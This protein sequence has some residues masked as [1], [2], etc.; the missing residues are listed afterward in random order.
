[1]R[2]RKI[3]PSCGPAGAGCSYVSLDGDIACLVNGAGLAMSTMDLIKYHGGE[4]ANFLDVGGGANKDQVLEGFRILLSAPARQGGAGQ[5]LRRHH[6]VRHDRNG[7]AGGLSTSSI[8]AFRWSSGS[9]GP[10]SSWARSSSR[11]AGARSSPPT[12]SPTRPR[13]SSRRPRGRRETCELFE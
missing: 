4:P 9:K 3:R 13:R 10:T 5:H 1:M 11:R 2:P 12:G 7:P 6:E 8:S